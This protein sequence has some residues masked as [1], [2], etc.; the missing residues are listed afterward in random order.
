MN[1]YQ[2]LFR[3]QQKSGWCGPAVIQMAMLSAG[4]KK[5]QSA[6]AR[7]VYQK[8]W[9]TNQ[10]TI[11]AYLSQ[12]FK[13][14]GFKENSTLRNI[15]YHLTQKHFVI[16]NW[17]DNLTPDEGEDGHYS[18]IFA[19]DSKSKLITLGDPSAGRGI[20]QMKAADFN[21]RWY[22]SLDVHGKKWIS[23]WLLWLDP[24]SVITR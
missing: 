22:D 20:W 5:T 24:K 13:K 14:L 6:I 8:W 12:Y 2:H 3:Y 9:G 17:W 19:Y 10:Q 11:Y 1:K 18:V 15:T 7:E 4:I 21:N 16:V 23:G